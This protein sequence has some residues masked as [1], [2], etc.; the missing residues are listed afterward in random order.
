MT[1]PSE[2]AGQTARSLVT[3]LSGQPMTLALVVF[4]ICF[5]AVVYLSVRDQRARAE[6]FQKQ[7]FEQQ[8]KTMEMLYHCVPPPHEQQQ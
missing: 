2:E 6:D 4:N 7:L 3:A 1:G 5:I 8:T